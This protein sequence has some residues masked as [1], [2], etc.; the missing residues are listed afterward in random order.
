MASVNVSVPETLQK[1]VQQ[2]IESGQYASVNEYV[3]ELIRRD[4]EAETERQLSVAG[5]RKSIEENRASGK[6][7]PADE[8]FARIETKLRAVL[9]RG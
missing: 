3:R 4:Q 2:R 9:D 1:W 8:V 5:I 6:T 7:N